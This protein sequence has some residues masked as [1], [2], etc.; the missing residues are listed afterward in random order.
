MVQRETQNEKRTKDGAR[1][2][3]MSDTAEEE[4]QNPKE[5][6]KPLQMVTAARKLKDVAP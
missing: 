4:D 2:G 6:P 5:N 3:N 1:G